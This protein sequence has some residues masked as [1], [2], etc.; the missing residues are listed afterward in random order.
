MPARPG[1]QLVER[2]L[3]A[4]ASPR[5][6]WRPGN[7]SIDEHQAR[8]RRR[9]ARR[10]SAADGPRPPSAT[11]PRRSDRRALDR[12]LGEVLAA[13]RSAEMCWM[14]SRW[15]GVSMKPPVPG[16]EASR[17]VSGET[18]SALPVVSMTWIERDARVAQPRRVDLHLQL[19]V[20][21]APDR[22]RSR[23]PGRPSGA[24]GSSSGRAP[25]SRSGTAS[26]SESPIIIT[27]L[28]DDSGWSIIGGFETLRQRVRL[29]QAL[30]HHLARARRCRCPARRRR[31]IDDRPGTDSERMSSSHG[32]AVEQVLLE[33]HGDQLLDLRRRQAE[34]LG[35]DLD[36]RRRELGQTS[37]G[38]ERS[39][40]TPKIIVA[41]AIATTSSR[42]AG[43]TRRSSGS[44]RRP[45]R[46][47][48]R[49]AARPGLAEP[50]TLHRHPI[51][52]RSRRSANRAGARSATAG[53]RLPGSPSC[54]PAAGR[55]Y[56]TSVG[57][58]IGHDVVWPPQRTQ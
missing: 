4:L 33:R 14:P 24:A 46:T 44:S 15:F 43:S 55:R 3:D 21:L 36:V 47:V 10:R 2:F 29:G 28:V 16:V 39:W 54:A 41:A 7:F 8:S 1:L 17:K 5:A 48:E 38:I 9:R 25:T 30:L 18:H 56:A 11:S 13:S 42:N 20:A 27:R 32:D 50:A 49:G 52:P 26:S 37:T 19:P 31:T 34:R 23:R 35:L 45:P 53:R 51:V 22:R 6:C 57:H 58:D 40:A 12:H